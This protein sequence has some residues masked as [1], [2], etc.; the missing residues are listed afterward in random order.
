[1]T[2]NLSRGRDIAALL[3]K[4]GAS[5][6]VKLLQWWG[7]LAGWITGRWVSLHARALPPSRPQA[8]QSDRR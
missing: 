1:M 7:I 8:V 5:A 2:C 3:Q 6:C 4:R